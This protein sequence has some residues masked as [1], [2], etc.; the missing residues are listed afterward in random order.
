MLKKVD[1]FGINYAVVDYHS[2]VDQIMEWV[3]SIK[4]NSGSKQGF[5]VTALAVHRLKFISIGLEISVS[6]LN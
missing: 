1:L 5:G 2:A 6:S 4:N 3:E